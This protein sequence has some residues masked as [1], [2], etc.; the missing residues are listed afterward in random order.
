MVDDFDEGF[1]R[2]ATVFGIILVLTFGSFSASLETFQGKQVVGFEGTPID[3]ED[4]EGSAG[5][6]LKFGLF[7]IS[8]VLFEGGQ[9]LGK[10]L[11]GTHV[12]D[13]I[14]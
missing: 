12:V 6:K 8:I 11:A 14:G 2:P 13:G 10:F 4:A 5:V 1:D 3:F 9:T 7:S